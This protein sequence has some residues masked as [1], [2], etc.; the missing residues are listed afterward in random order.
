MK[1]NKKYYLGALY[2]GFILSFKFW[3]IEKFEVPYSLKPGKYVSSYSFIQGS[4]IKS[5]RISK[6]IHD[7]LK[8]EKIKSGDIVYVDADSF[9]TFYH[10]IF[11]KI[12]APFVMVI[13]SKNSTFPGGLSHD[14]DVDSFLSDCRVTQVF[15]QNCDYQGLHTNITCIPCGLDFLKALNQRNLKIGRRS[16]MAQ[17]RKID[18]VVA[19]L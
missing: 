9:P 10:E 6:N 15:A 5:T 14:I 12:N 17:E 18:D 4:D 3:H 13:T 1:K 11:P 19:K 16:P 7:Y 2:I 8:P